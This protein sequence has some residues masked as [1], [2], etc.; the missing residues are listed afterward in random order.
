MGTLAQL[1]PVLGL[2]AGFIVTKMTPY[3]FKQGEK[4]F[5]L[6]MY[7]LLAVAIG[8]LVWQYTSN[9]PF[10]VA[11]PL[12]LFLIPVGTLY[13]KRHFLLGGIAI[14]YAAI[15]LLLF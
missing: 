3:E 9:K 4:Y 11:V 2:L 12:F 1:A 14:A 15:A 10:D 6:L 7:A 13:H 5:R 8:I